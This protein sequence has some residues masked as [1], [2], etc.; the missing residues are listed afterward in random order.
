M[1]NYLTKAHVLNVKQTIAKV[2]ALIRYFNYRQR[3]LEPRLQLIE[4]K[5]R[6]RKPTFSSWHG[7]GNIH[8]FVSD[9]LLVYKIM[10][11]CNKEIPVIISSA[12]DLFGLS[13]VS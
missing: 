5:N 2:W 12:R 10:S 13:T 3:L 9:S 8:D 7:V 4:R 1:T 11:V 6:E